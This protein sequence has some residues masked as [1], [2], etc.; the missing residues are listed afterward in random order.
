MPL[1]KLYVSWMKHEAYMDVF[2]ACFLM[3]TLLLLDLLN[4]L[5]SSEYFKLSYLNPE[6]AQLLYGY[7]K[8]ITKND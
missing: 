5:N 2:T 6:Y 1:S 3:N 8:F 7:Q 4:T